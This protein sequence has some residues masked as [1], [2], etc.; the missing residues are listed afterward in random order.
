MSK[1]KRK[2][3]ARVVEWKPIFKALRD[4]RIKRDKRA[5]RKEVAFGVCPPIGEC[6]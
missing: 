3:I 4:A 1:D 5:A 2:K 6:L